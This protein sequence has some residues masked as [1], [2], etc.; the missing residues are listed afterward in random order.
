MHDAAKSRLVCKPAGFRAAAG[1]LALLALSA[2]A[3]QPHLFAGG[4]QP[5]RSL[6]TGSIAPPSTEKDRTTDSDAQG[7]G[8]AAGAAVAAVKEGDA[9]TPLAWTDGASGT[10]GIVSQIRTTRNGDEVCRAFT[11]T[12]HSYRGIALY[13]GR[14][15]SRDGETWN[16]V[17]FAP[18]DPDVQPLPAPPG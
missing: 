7:D 12:R 6:V 18:K 8:E 9:S 1:V 14:T 16:L 17:V 10:T 4:T 13:E 11:T 5:D 3:R 2:C 15:C